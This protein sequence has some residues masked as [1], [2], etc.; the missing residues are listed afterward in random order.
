MFKKRQYSRC[1]Q[2]QFN[3]GLDDIPNNKATSIFADLMCSPRTFNK[4]KTYKK[5]IDKF[6]PKGC[7]FSITF[8]TRD[9]N[10]QM[11]RKNLLNFKQ[12]FKNN[13]KKQG[14]IPIFKEKIKSNKHR[15]TRGGYVETLYY[16]IK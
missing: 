6:H 3:D 7:S 16:I 9:T 11:Y 14:F 12:N 4:K 10:G 15:K 13:C 8:S 5:I 2:K 1:I